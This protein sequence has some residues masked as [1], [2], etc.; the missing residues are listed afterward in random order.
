MDSFWYPY[1]YSSVWAF[2]AVSESDITNVAEDIFF[3]VW[4]HWEDLK[5]AECQRREGVVLS[6]RQT[7]KIL[8]ESSPFDSFVGQ[9]SQF[10]DLTL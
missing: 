10:L 8:S 2:I 7:P 1:S 3:H 4:E 6:E 5:L 9:D